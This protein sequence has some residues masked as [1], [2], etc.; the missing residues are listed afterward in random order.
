MET[1]RDIFIILFS[2]V[3]ILVGLVLLFSAI[4]FFRKVNGLIGSAGHVVESVEKV[5]DKVSD[6][7]SISSTLGG[8]LGFLSGSRQRGKKK[9]DA[10]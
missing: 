9:D 3:G 10:V 5:A 1:T 7:S 8:L 2:G 6:G 4:Y